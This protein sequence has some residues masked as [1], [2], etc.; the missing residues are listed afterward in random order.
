MIA[1]SGV[2]RCYVYRSQANRPIALT[3]DERREVEGGLVIGLDPAPSADSLR[4]AEVVPMPELPGM[5]VLRCV[6]ERRRVP[7]SALAEEIDRRM[8]EGEREGLT[9][10]RRHVRAAALSDLEARALPDRR[11]HGAWYDVASATLYVQGLDAARSHTVALEVYRALRAAGVPTGQPAAVLDEVPAHVVDALASR[12]RGQSHGLT[13]DERSVAVRSPLGTVR[14]RQAP[15][16]EDGPSTRSLLD[17]EL[18]AEGERTIVGARIAHAG[19][20]WTLAEDA[21]P[22]LEVPAG[23]DDA[24]RI[25]ELAGSWSA[26]VAAVRDVIDPDDAASLLRPAA[27][28]EHEAQVDI[29]TAIEDMRSRDQFDED[30]EEDPEWTPTPPE[31]RAEAEARLR[32]RRA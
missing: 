15:E 8:A 5:I 26:L 32:A 25:V 23:G 7:A 22:R 1:R 14:M 10:S 21:A 2:I 20:S 18:D 29:V 6:R 31:E 17:V 12:A 16:E 27:Q 13:L 19:G 4:I 24:T 28:P 9:L 3:A 30:A 11:T